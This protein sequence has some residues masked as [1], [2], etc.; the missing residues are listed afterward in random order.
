[1]VVGPGW[2]WRWVARVSRKVVIWLLLGS[3]SQVIS[4][5]REGNLDSRGWRVLAFRRTSPSL[6]WTV[7]VT[8]MMAPSSRD[9]P[10]CS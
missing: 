7:P 3:R 5:I 2:E 1:M 4:L 6:F 8:T 10:Y 9:L